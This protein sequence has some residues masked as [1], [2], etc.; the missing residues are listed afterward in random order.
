MG[1]PEQL[2]PNA[3]HRQRNRLKLGDLV[4]LINKFKL[5]EPYLFI[6]PQRCYS[7]A[8]ARCDALG[9]GRGW[10]GGVPRTPYPRE[11][12]CSQQIRS[13]RA[14]LASQYVCVSLKGCALVRGPSMGSLGPSVQRSP[15]SDQFCM[16]P[17]ELGSPTGGHRSTLLEPPNR[18]QCPQ[19]PILCTE[20]TAHDGDLNRVHCAGAAQA[21][22]TL[23]GVKIP[24][25]PT[26]STESKVVSNCG[27]E[28]GT[29]PKGVVQDGSL[30]AMRVE[31]GIPPADGTPTKASSCTAAKSAPSGDCARLMQQQRMLDR[32]ISGHREYSQWNWQADRPELVPKEEVT[33]TLL[34]PD[35]ILDDRLMGD[36]SGGAVR[37]IISSAA[38]L[39]VGLALPAE[40]DRTVAGPKTGISKPPRA[41]RRQQ[42]R[43]RLCWPRSALAPVHA[44]G[45]AQRCS[46]RAEGLDSS[47]RMDGG[48]AV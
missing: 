45:A 15:L 17:N 47:R 31:S 35:R 28:E 32:V 1:R 29:A 6:F 36:A 13:A 8:G 46:S 39:S 22:V 2:R 40:G 16:G 44:E 21:P 3:V 25:L 42:K 5:T 26:S 7:A 23:E 9:W 30:N 19:E 12:S 20:R 48:E 33:P 18:L 37:P 11:D 4:D 34:S 38:P 14:R 41:G 27:I 24:M 43:R 10:C